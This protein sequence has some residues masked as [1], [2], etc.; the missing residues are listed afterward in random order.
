LIKGKHEKF[1][2]V[3]YSRSTKVNIS[4]KEDFML[5][6][7]GEVLKVR[8]AAFEIIPKGI[9]LVVPSR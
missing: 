4:S 5:N 6:I 9:R 7:D 1:R 2:E 8:E 3:S